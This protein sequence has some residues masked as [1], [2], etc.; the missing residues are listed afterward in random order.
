MTKRITNS[1]LV[2]DK[3]GYWPQF[4]DAKLKRFLFDPEQNALTMLLSYNDSDNN[5]EARVEFNFT[6][7]SDFQLSS[8]KEDNIFDELRIDYLNDQFH[9]VIDSCYGLAGSFNCLH[10]ET[11]LK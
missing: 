7:L 9:V 10:I 1:N 3:F 8:L 2:I 5:V 6:Q 11:S 4:C